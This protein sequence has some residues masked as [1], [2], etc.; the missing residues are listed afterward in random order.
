MRVHS[1]LLQLIDKYGKSTTHLLEWVPRNCPIPATAA[2]TES[3]F[4]AKL[5]LQLNDIWKGLFLSENP[6]LLLMSREHMNNQS[7]TTLRAKLC[8]QYFTVQ[9]STHP[10][11]KV[12]SWIPDLRGRLGWGEE[13]LAA[14]SLNM[15]G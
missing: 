6:L 9:L 13:A 4:E 1:I 5:C 12:R 15:I 11:C 10:D 7:V 2:G 3:T 8:N 14:A